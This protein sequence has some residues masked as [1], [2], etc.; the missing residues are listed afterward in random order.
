[1]ARSELN[2]H[3][4]IVLLPSSMLM[5]VSDSR[6]KRNRT[7]TVSYGKD[8]LSL[9][10]LG[11]KWNQIKIICQQPY[12]RTE[13]FG[14]Q[15]VA[16][17]SEANAPQSPSNLLTPPHNPKLLSSP[18]TAPSPNIPSHT[19][20][21]GIGK[22]PT[23]TRQSYGKPNFKSPSAASTKS[24][25][26]KTPKRP[27]K[28]NAATKEEEF[29][30]SGVERQSRLFQNALKGK[31]SQEGNP[32]LE[33]IVSERDKYRKQSETLSDIPTYNRKRLLLKELPK[34]EGSVDFATSYEKGTSSN[35][36]VAAA[37]SRISAHGE[38]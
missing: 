25:T 31:S 24:E 1:M 18:L 27:A 9:T 28:E 8:R 35:K 22:L 38:H 5:S 30:F 29:E 2:P 12:N 10:A 16:V 7:K 11:K 21:R 17:Y 6:A 13:Q 26:L 23:L 4:F 34:V 3:D 36:D 20:S 33:K 32:I 19:S 37:F 15:H 14:L